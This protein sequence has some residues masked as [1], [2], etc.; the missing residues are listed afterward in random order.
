MNIYKIAIAVKLSHTKKGVV[1]M[2]HIFMV[3]DNL[4]M[5]TTVSKALAK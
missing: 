1:L 3:E 2:A 4:T 5:I